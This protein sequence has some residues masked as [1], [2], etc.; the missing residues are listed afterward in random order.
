MVNNETLLIFS[1]KQVGLYFFDL[2]DLYNP[3]FAGFLFG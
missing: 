3:S 1:I 2:T